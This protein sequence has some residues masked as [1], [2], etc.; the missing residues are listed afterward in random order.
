MSNATKYLSQGGFF[1][2][3][4]VSV[5]ADDFV[6]RKVEQFVAVSEKAANNPDFDV[7]VP[8]DPRTKFVTK[9]G[10][11]IGRCHSCEGRR[12]SWKRG[13][14]W[15]K[16][17]A[18]LETMRCP[19]CGGRL[20]QTTLALS[21]R[22]PVVPDALVKRLVAAAEKQ[23]TITWD[24]ETNE[25]EAIRNNF[26]ATIQRIK[27]EVEAPILEA[28]A[29]KELVRAAE[30]VLEQEKR[31]ATAVRTLSSAVLRAMNHDGLTEHEVRDAITDGLARHKGGER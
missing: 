23:A 15:R 31:T 17:L 4:R 12:S 10:H 9:K 21:S 16:G 30:W 14:A 26:A 2:S 8:E 28:E 27:A 3:F 13:M 29:A 11:A 1:N 19:R 18:T 24:M 20:Q 25:A 22:F 5:H 7:Q 6:D